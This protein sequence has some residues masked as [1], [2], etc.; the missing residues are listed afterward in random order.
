[1]KPKL[2]AAEVGVGA[3]CERPGGPWWIFWA[4]PRACRRE[5]RVIGRGLASTMEVGEAIG[6]CCNAL[7]VDG[8]MGSCTREV[9]CRAPGVVGSAVTCT[10]DVRC[11]ALGVADSAWCCTTEARCTAPGV[12]G[13]ATTCRTEARTEA[14]GLSIIGC[15]AFGEASGSAAERPTGCPVWLIG[16][17]YVTPIRVRKRRAAIAAGDILGTAAWTRVGDCGAAATAATPITAAATGGVVSVA[18]TLVRGEGTLRR[19]GLAFASSASCLAE[20]SSTPSL[21][22][23]GFWSRSPA[24]QGTSAVANSS[25]AATPA[26]G[27]ASAAPPSSAAGA[28]ATTKGAAVALKV[29]PLLGTPLQA[30]GASSFCTNAAD[31]RLDGATKAGALAL[32]W[33]SDLAAP[34]LTGPT[35]LG[36]QPIVLAPVARRPVL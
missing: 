12:A 13:S 8:S 16:E 27:N 6:L 28:V 11:T 18:S 21:S 22:C 36:L 30:I 5:L 20:A 24:S 26:S 33:N 34:A 2:C 4:T 23:L 25:A 35:T 19:A 32:N 31:I 17:L 3:N 1:M 9:R 7:G 10:T 14:V 29:K 15:T